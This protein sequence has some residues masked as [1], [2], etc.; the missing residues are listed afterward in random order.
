MKT[1]VE[2]IRTIA[3][4]LYRGKNIHINGIAWN[5]A[6]NI[7]YMNDEQIARLVGKGRS[8]VCLERNAALKVRLLDEIREVERIASEEF[9]MVFPIES[10][11]LQH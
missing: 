10:F 7:L 8:V 2:R 6:R 11:Q 4:S 1:K 9:S 3:K 5:V